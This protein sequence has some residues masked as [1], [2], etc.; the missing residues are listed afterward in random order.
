[1]N[2]NSDFGFR[3]TISASSY[4][5][6][7][8]TDWS[9]VRGQDVSDVKG[10]L[11]IH[12]EFAKANEDFGVRLQDPSVFFP[13]GWAVAV[14]RRRGLVPLPVPLKP[15]ITTVATSPRRHRDT[16]LVAFVAKAEAPR[17]AAVAEGYKWLGISGDLAIGRG[18]ST[19]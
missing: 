18:T 14:N 19:L 13:D 15:P 4:R 3:F 12:T 11:A 2:V 8:F 7:E 16:I 17:L 5:L 1:V 9:H 6:L 10:V